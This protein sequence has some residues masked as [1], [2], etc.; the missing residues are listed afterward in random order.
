MALIEL[1]LDPSARDLKWFGLIL[2]A[3]FGVV[4]VLVWRATGSL[5]WPRVIWLAAAALTLAYYVARPLRRPI[6]VGWSYTTY[7]IGW[8]VSHVLMA[9]VFF[10]VFT[11]VGLLMRL[12]RYDPLARTFDRSAKSYWIR[13]EDQPDVSYYFR[14]Y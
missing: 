3:F 7:P 1:R 6:Y 14:Q 13:H 11:T 4:G 8:V 9:V 2:L 12:F 10:G 5:A